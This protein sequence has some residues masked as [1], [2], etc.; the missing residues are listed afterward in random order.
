MNSL[1]YII[2]NSFTGVLFQVGKVITKF[3]IGSDTFMTIC[4][5]SMFQ[6]K[7]TILIRLKILCSHNLELIILV[8]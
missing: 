7:R 2:G 6:M 1:A 3:I 4:C 5:R 8:M